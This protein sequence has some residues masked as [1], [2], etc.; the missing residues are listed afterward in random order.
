MGDPVK[1]Q[2]EPDYAVSPGEVLSAELE[3]RGMSQLELSH[4]TGLT[5]KHINSVLKGKSAISPETAIK[6]ERTIGMPADYWLNLE[7]NYQ[8]IRARISEAE[9]LERDLDWLKRVPVNRMAK[10]G[11]ITKHN[12]K[13][14]QL[15]EVLRFFGI[16]SVDQWEEVW[17][18]LSVAY[19]QNEKFE[20][21]PEAVSAWLRQGELQAAAVECQPYD[22]NRFRKALDEI[23]A[24]T[25]L[26]PDE[27]APRMRELCASA[28][29][30]VVFVPALPK[31]AVSGATR[32]IKPDKAVIQLSLRYR[33]NDHLWFTFFHE[34][35]HIVRHGKKD[36]FIEQNNKSGNGLDEAKEEEANSFAQQTLIPESELKKFIASGSPNRTS[37]K[38]FAQSVG[39][40]P[41][42]VVGQLQYRRILQFSM[43]N[44]L[45]QYYKWSHEAGG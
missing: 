34:A 21:F 13:K 16:A 31:T 15:I 28:G 41:G 14:A 18:N 20:I 37:I 22:K 33:T 11:W 39:I 2:Y 36:L 10:L 35:G 27:F 12:D 43:F 17:P 1:N 26:P 9:K 25:D 29:V 19:R 32:W 24:L 23:R 40:A 6:L 7:S 4:R 42:I 3:I 30:A 38:Q 45:K 8:A 5:P 44:D